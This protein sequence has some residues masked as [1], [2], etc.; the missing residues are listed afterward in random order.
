MLKIQT[1]LSKASA[2]REGEEEF[3]YDGKVVKTNC[4]ASLEQIFKWYKDSLQLYMLFA[5]N[6]KIE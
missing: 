5:S 1:H 3:M 4:D 2:F 6:S